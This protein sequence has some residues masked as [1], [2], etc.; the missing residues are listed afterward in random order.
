MREKSGASAGHRVIALANLSCIPA[1]LG[2]SEFTARY[3]L[4][5][6]I[7]YSVALTVLAYGAVCIALDTYQARQHDNHREQP[8]KPH[9]AG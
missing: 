2:Y 3:D 9:I 4:T 5:K 7:V 6:W 8:G 1:V